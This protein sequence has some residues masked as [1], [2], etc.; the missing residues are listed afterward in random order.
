MGGPPSLGHSQ[1]SFDATILPPPADEAEMIKRINVFSS[2]FQVCAHLLFISSLSYVEDLP[3][4][5]L[6]LTG[7]VL[8]IFV[9]LLTS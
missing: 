2:V 7:L 6:K 4:A 1:Q 5:G 3:G 8:V 9:R